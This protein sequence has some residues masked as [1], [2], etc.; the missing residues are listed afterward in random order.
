MIACLRSAGAFF[1]VHSLGKADD[2]TFAPVREV[3][4]V[5]SQGWKL[6]ITSSRRAGRFFSC[7][8]PRG[9]L[10][11]HIRDVL[12]VFPVG[13]KNKIQRIKLIK[14]YMLT[15]GCWRANQR[16]KC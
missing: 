14:K 12:E 8:E 1:P 16:N 9:S 10:W 3:F 11:S 15:Y 2:R 4:T 13:G 7:G 6:K 5:A